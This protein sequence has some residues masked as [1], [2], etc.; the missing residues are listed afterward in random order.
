MDF[1]GLAEEALGWTRSESWS[2]GWVTLNGVTER[3][4]VQQEYGGDAV[5]PVTLT[6]TALQLPP[7]IA[8]CFVI[9]NIVAY[10]WFH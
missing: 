2:L 6:V 1:L 8:Q 10:T 7:N 9:E 5:N 3:R 4:A